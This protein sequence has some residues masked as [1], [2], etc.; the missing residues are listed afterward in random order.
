MP[1][2]IVVLAILYIIGGI[3]SL[4]WGVV[5]I[6]VG[7]VSWITGLL[8]SSTMREFGGSAFWGGF[9]GIG[10]AI[11]NF[12]VGFGLFARQKWAY[13]LAWI[14]AAFSLVGPIAGLLGG[15]FWALFGLII[16]G[17]IFSYLT[18][19]ENVKQTFGRG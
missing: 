11:L 15:N 4:V 19:N 13:I 1:A 9:W 17:A 2:G 7:S 10:S 6:S 14:A 12:A 16:P 3:L 5:A 18:F 8:F